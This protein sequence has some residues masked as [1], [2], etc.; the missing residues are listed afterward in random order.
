MN[1]SSTSELTTYKCRSRPEHVDPAPTGVAAPSS[2]VAGARSFLTDAAS[3][4]TTFDQASRVLCTTATLNF[5]VK[6]A[7]TCCDPDN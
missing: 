6:S 5:N 3:H 4:N 7:R 1:V 2:R